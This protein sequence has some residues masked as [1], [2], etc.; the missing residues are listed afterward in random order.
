MEQMSTL[1][2]SISGI[3][4]GFLVG[5]LSLDPYQVSTGILVFMAV[6][7]Y[8]ATGQIF[9]RAF[10]LFSKKNEKGELKYDF[11]WWISNSAMVY[12]GFWFIIWVV[13]YNKFLL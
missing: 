9:Q 12:F 13:V 1:I 7:L 10:D 2:H 11:K 4:V 6:A 8:L 5:F 3:L